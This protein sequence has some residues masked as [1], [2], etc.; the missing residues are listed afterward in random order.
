MSRHPWHDVAG[1]D[2]HDPRPGSP[3]P[4]VHPERYQLA[5]RK[6]A[7]KRAQEAVLRLRCAEAFADAMALRSEW[8]AGTPGEA[9]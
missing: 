2:K 5:M 8:D 9:D 1:P 4:L 6:V 3:A 7:G